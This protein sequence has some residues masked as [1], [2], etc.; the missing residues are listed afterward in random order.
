MT[1]PKNNSIQ[2]IITLS[3]SLI[4]PHK[5]NRSH[6][7]IDTVWQLPPQFIDCS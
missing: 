1:G 6:F 4:D 3:Y 2:P 5:P 7:I